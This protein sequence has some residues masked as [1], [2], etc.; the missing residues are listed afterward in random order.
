MMFV[1]LFICI[2]SGGYK[3][4]G[5][6]VRLLIYIFF[7]LKNPRYRMRPSV[8]LLLGRTNKQNLIL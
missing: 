5:S 8:H 4:V 1:N 6:D 3:E 7:T 2:T